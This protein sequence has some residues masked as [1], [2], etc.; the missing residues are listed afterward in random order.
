MKKNHRLFLLIL[1]II[2]IFYSVI[3]LQ[4]LLGIIVVGL[5][6]LTLILSPPNE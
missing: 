4:V 3:S 5:I 2:V 6:L 1:G